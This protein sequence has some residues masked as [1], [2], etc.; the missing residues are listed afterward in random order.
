MSIFSTIKLFIKG[1]C[2]RIRGEEPI[3]ILVKRGMEIGKNFKCMNDVW[4]DPGHCWLIKFGDNVTLA[5]RVTV[6]AHD[7]SPQAFIGV[8]KIG[9]VV[10]G[11]NVFIGAGSIV[12]PGVRIGD[13]VVIGAGSVVAKDIPSGAV[14]AG[15]PCKPI[16]DIKSYVTDVENIENEFDT[17]YLYPAID[18]EKKNEMYNTLSNRR[19]AKLVRKG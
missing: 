7:A 5:P 3:H 11:N 16:K 4:I 15:N 14:A 19:F 9:A 2:L 10:V 12:L 13:N 8:T 6:L 1:I 18:D 17:L